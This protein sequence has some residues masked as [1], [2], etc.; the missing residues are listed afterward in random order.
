MVSGDRTDVVAIFR[1]LGATAEVTAED[2]RRYIAD[3]A[4]SGTPHP[5]DV[6]FQERFGA[7]ST[8]EVSHEGDVWALRHSRPGTRGQKWT[9]YS[10]EGEV[11]RRVVLPDEIIVRSIRGGR[12]YGTRTDDLGLQTVVVFPIDPLRASGEG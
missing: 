4:E 2:R 5:D 7:Y 11:V 12:L 6:P 9:V 10:P 3:R 8:L 1:E